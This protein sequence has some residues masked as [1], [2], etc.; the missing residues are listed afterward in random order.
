MAH[1]R[2]EAEN[3]RVILS[4]ESVAKR[5]LHYAD[6]L[7]NL[8]IIEWDEWADVLTHVDTDGRLLRGG[9]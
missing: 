3:L 6:G 8:R 7:T 1:S 2:G 5:F 4:T 9:K